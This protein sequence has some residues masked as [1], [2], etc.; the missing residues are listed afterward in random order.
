MSSEQSQRNAQANA[1]V[2]KLDEIDIGALVISTVTSTVKRRPIT[3]SL[4]VLGLLL[5][6]FAT[7]FKVDDVQAESYHIQLQQ[8]QEVDAK[9][10]NKA[11][12][13]LGRAEEEHYKKKG[14]FWSCDRACQEAQDKVQMAKGAVKRVQQKRDM[15]LT[16]ARKEVG[17]WST[18]GVTDVRASFW[19]AWK[20]GKDM[21]KRWTMMDAMFMAFS[22]SREE[23]IMGVILKLVMQYIINLTLG[24]CGAFVYFIYSVYYLIQSYGEPTLSGI[25]FF[26]LVLV[27]GMATL[28][29]YLAAIYGT[30]VGGGVYLVK[31]AAKHAALNEGE[32][33][34]RRQQVQ[35]GNH[36]RQQPGFRPHQQ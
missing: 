8:A 1:A 35:F 10:L 22:S 2:Q 25:A 23:N 4:W 31:Q 7:G 9:E 36:G 15:L 12:R 5:A 28:G 17:I 30:V 29:S 21:A 20:S 34:R 13:N 6:A 14:W 18:F 3:F 11:E 27:T 24:L 16:E 32:G 33:G 19:S 26:L